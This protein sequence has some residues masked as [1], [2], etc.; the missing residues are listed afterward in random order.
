MEPY[1]TDFKNSHKNIF[2]PWLQT[3]QIQSSLKEIWNWTKLWRKQTK[4]TV[5]KHQQLVAEA[6]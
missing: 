4:T 1:S 3:L 6:P 2:I 5:T